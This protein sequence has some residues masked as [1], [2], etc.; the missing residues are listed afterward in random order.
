MLFWQRSKRGKRQNRGAQSRWTARPA[1]PCL[2][3]S[4]SVPPPPPSMEAWVFQ[5]LSSLAVPLRAY[6]SKIHASP[7]LALDLGC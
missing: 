6:L 7:S 3:L 4:Q 1:S 5:A 2:T